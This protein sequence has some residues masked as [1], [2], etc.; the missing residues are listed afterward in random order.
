[1]TREVPPLQTGSGYET[2]ER[3]REEETR[4][5]SSR[6]ESVYT[7]TPVSHANQTARIAHAVHAVY[8]CAYFA[9]CD[10][11]RTSSPIPDDSLHA[12]QAKAPLLPD[13]VL[14]PTKHTHTAATLK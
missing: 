5:P 4:V 14:I 6:T 9:A 3:E 1:M 13:Y 2:K 10:G 12:D 8:V 11:L 7:N